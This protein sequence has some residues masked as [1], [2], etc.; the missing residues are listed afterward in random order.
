MTKKGEPSASTFQ[1]V[2][3]EID[4]LD[5]ALKE[6]LAEDRGISRPRTGSVDQQEPSAALAA[7]IS[8]RDDRDDESLSDS[9]DRF[10]R[11]NIE[12]QFP[13]RG[14]SILSDSMVQ[15]L[16]ER[17]PETESQWFGAVPIGLRQAMDPKQRGF[18]ED[19][20]DLVAEY[21]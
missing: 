16:V 3:D 20:L 7:D 13:D 9:L 2:T 15:L 8:S 17:R 14:T 18:L 4:R 19:I 11:Q 10:W 12:L 1:S 6:R 21:S 5:R